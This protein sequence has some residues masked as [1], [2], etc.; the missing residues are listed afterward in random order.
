[1]NNPL[2][3]R[4]E[5]RHALACLW[6]LDELLAISDEATDIKLIVEYARAAMAVA[7]Y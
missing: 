3:L 7:V 4:I 2:T 6:V 1:M 5:A